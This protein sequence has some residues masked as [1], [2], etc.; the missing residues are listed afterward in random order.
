[1]CDAEIVTLVSDVITQSGGGDARRAVGVESGRGA[2]IADLGRGDGGDGAA[3]AV[4]YD[5]DFVGRVRSC[6]GFE[7]GEDAGAGFEPAVVADLGGGKISVLF[8]CG[9]RFLEKREMQIGIGSSREDY[10]QAL[11]AE[12]LRADVGCDKGKV[13][14]GGPVAEGMRAAEGKDCKFEGMIDGYVASHACEGT[15]T[16]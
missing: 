13:E 14:I 11:V 8:L 16:V 6:G 4:A 2:G 7:G 15:G 12:A 9:V 10:V 1:M 3:E 5:D